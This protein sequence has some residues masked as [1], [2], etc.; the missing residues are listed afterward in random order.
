MKKHY[1]VTAEALVSAKL[2]VW[3]PDFVEDDPQ[4]CMIHIMRPERLLSFDET[5]LT[6]DMT[7]GSKSKAERIVNAG[8]GDEGEVLVNK[9]GGVASAI[10]GSTSTG[11]S[12]PACIVFGGADS[13]LADWTVGAPVSTRIDPST[14]RGYPTT[15]YANKKG[16]MTHALCLQYF[17]NNIR[18]I[19]PGCSVENPV[20]VICDGHGS[21]LSCELLAYCREEGII[22]ILRPPHTTSISQGEDVVNFPVFKPD[23][24]VAK[25]HRLVDKLKS[26]QPPYLS[27]A[28][29][30]AVTTPA[31]HKAFSV[32]NNL[33]AW[34]RIGIKP[35]TRCVYWEL[36]R[37]EKAA[38][39]T[40]AKAEGVNL[41]VLTFGFKGKARKETQEEE[42]EEEGE[43]AGTGR[44]KSRVSS[45]LFWDKGPMTSDASFAAVEQVAKEKQ[46]A[47]EGTVARKRQAAAKELERSAKYQKLAERAQEKLQVTRNH[48]IHAKLV[49]DDLVGVLRAMGET[50]AATARKGDLEELL[51]KLLGQP[52]SWG[53]FGHI[54]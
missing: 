35:F 45:S 39:K 2:A 17:Q 53:P 3:N 13:F 31:W 23:F 28:D 21:H 48:V 51:Q 49:K 52:G 18:P 25:A 36:V 6:M 42:E 29:L 30:M 4:S 10:G 54:M 14:G 1:Q 26:G 24:R 38:E 43:E 34:A 9:G 8:E 47:A 41:E 15:F 12:L 20:A 33:K 37:K 5:R 16:G 46:R 7:D 22:I 40:V 50:P 19:F 32:E 11:E 44:G 27:N